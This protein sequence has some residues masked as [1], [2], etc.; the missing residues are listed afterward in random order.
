MAITNFHTILRLLLCSTALNQLFNK[1]SGRSNYYNILSH[2]SY[3]E[4]NMNPLTDR[5]RLLSGIWPSPAAVS[6]YH[7][8]P[9][10]YFLTLLHISCYFID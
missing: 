5:V 9:I 3:C 2:F 4:D 6:A 10:K 7:C 8:H 1:I